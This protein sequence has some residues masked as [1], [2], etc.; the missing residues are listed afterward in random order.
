ML[1]LVTSVMITLAM[2]T[3][4]LPLRPPPLPPPLHQLLP[5]PSPPLPQPPVPTSP[6][7][8]P[9]RLAVSSTM[10]TT[11][12]KAPPLRLRLLPLPLPS[13]PVTVTPMPMEVNDLWSFLWCFADMSS[14]SLCLSWIRNRR[15]SRTFTV[16]RCELERQEVQEESTQVIMMKCNFMLRYLF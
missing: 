11:T 8:L 2:L 13:R 4:P 15:E 6:P 1:A 16:D 3:P 14:C 9:S 12:V 7:H 5:L 10:T